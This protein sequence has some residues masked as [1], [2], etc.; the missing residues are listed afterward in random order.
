MI[1]AT[2]EHFRSQSFDAF[3]ITE[4]DDTFTIGTVPTGRVYALGIDRQSGNLEW[5]NDTPF[6]YMHFDPNVIDPAQ[7]GA[8]PIDVASDGHGGYTFTVGCHTSSSLDL[9]FQLGSGNP[10]HLPCPSTDPTTT[11][12]TTTTTPTTDPAPAPSEPPVLMTG[13]RA[14]AIG[15]T[16]LDALQKAL[17]GTVLAGF[18]P[19]SNLTGAPPPSLASALAQVPGPLGAVAAEIYIAGSKLTQRPHRSPGVKQQAKPAGDRNRPV[20]PWAIAVVALMFAAVL[21]LM[22]IRRGQVSQR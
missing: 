7:L 22:R 15:S 8:T 2:A 9:V 6:D 18:K 20:P 21:G 13:S 11:T 10:Q 4:G 14:L 17:A 19:S 16:A 5:W 1:L 12:T 3:G